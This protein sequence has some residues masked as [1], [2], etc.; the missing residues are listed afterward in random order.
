V[1]TQQ[2][3]STLALPTLGQPSEHLPTRVVP[4][5]EL[6]SRAFDVPSVELLQQRGA[7]QSAAAQVECEV[8]QR[9]ELTLGE[10]G[11]AIRIGA[12][13]IVQSYQPVDRSGELGDVLKEKR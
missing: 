8:H 10:V 4:P 11:E 2:E 12:S 3:Q 7:S 5:K 1:C 6:G 9:I 13:C